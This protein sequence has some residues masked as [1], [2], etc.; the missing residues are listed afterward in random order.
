MIMVSIYW[1]I[2]VLPKNPKNNSVSSTMFLQLTIK[3][4]AFFLGHPVYTS[5]QGPPQPGGGGGGTPT[6]LF[7]SS[8]KSV[9]SPRLGIAVSS[10]MTDLCDKQACKN[11]GKKQRKQQQQQ[12]QERGGGG[13][14]NP[15]TPPHTPESKGN[16]ILCE[17]ENYIDK[18][19]PLRT[20]K[21]KPSSRCSYKHNINHCYSVDRI[22]CHV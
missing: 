15:L 9:Q 4:I 17:L 8:K 13:D 1:K 10:Y 22:S 19:I 5:N 12:K 7:S 20:L 14:L 16:L 2:N 21:I 11:T 6:L 3:V 18:N